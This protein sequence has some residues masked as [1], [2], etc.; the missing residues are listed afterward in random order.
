[1]ASGLS[2]VDESFRQI[3]GNLRGFGQANNTLVVL[4][5]HNGNSP[6]VGAAVQL[7]SDYLTTPVTNDGIGLRQITSDD[8]ALVWLYDSSQAA[9]AA[10]DIAG[11]DPN[12]IDSV[13]SGSALLAAGFG[14][15]ASD[16]RA[17][18]LVVKFK[19][20]YL[21][22]SGKMSE[23]GGFSDDDTHVALLVGGEGLDAGVKG[24]TIDSTVSQKQVAVT[25]LLALG[26]DPSQLQ[27]VQIEGTTALPTSVPEPMGV[28]M[29][30]VGGVL[31]AARRRRGFGAGTW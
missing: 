31:M 11:I 23:H 30:V 4:T 13:L 22:G 6:R 29:M 25:T 19:P 12:V 20:G 17:P 18:D 8:S 15:P 26:L 2:H 14:D 24:L 16:S 10:A 9:R 21:I 3:L 5:S 7:A 1:M 28:G 27:G